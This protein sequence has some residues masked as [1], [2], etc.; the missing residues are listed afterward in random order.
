[1]YLYYP[2]SFIFLHP[3]GFLT[4]KRLIYLPIRAHRSITVNRPT[5]PLPYRP[6]RLPIQLP[7][8]G[9]DIFAELGMVGL[10][11]APFPTYFITSRADRLISIPNIY[12]YCYSFPAAR[13]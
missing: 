11:M 8:G 10:Y 2:F 4:K 12:L 1:M 9:I 5:M 6:S 13:G 3:G 7:R